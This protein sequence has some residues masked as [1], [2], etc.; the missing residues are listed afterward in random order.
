VS[1][2]FKFDADLVLLDPDDPAS[3]GHTIAFCHQVKAAWNM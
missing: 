1:L 2:F 3:F